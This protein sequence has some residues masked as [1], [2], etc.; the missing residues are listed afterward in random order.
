MASF[1]YQEKK[2]L[3][4][5]HF[6]KPVVS[7]QSTASVFV[8]WPEQTSDHFVS[9]QLRRADL[10]V[11]V[12]TRCRCRSQSSLIGQ[13]GMQQTFQLQLLPTR[14][15]AAPAATP[16]CLQV[17]YI[18]TCRV[19][20]LH[21]EGYLPRSQGPKMLVA[22]SACKHQGP[23]FPLAPIRWNFLTSTK[24]SSCPLH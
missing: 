12:S 19:Q 4:H 23:A 11:H 6:Q 14:R 7:L 3:G 16:G 24:A 5:T 21:T 15:A 18:C 20:W 1:K 2:N 9:A 17:Q 22:G 13:L 8:V 10:S